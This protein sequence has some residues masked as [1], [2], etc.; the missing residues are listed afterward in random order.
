MV[1]LTQIAF[2]LVNKYTSYRIFRCIS[3]P[4]KTKILPPKI[5]LDLITQGI[6]IAS[7]HI[8]LYIINI[9]MKQDNDSLQHHNPTYIQT[10]TFNRRFTRPFSDRML[11]RRTKFH[12]IMSS[13][14]SEFLKE[15]SHKHQQ[16]LCKSYSNTRFSFHVTLIEANEV[17]MLQ[18]PQSQ[19][20]MADFSVFNVFPSNPVKFYT[21]YLRNVWCRLS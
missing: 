9:C 14:Q 21:K 1:F 13:P 16:F 3:R 15:K 17:N 8:A 6:K 2:Q 18:F 12:H 4:F 11:T 19:S 5:G 20:N 7:S 10:S